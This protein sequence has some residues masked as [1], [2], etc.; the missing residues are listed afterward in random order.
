MLRGGAVT[1][2]RRPIYRDAA[3]AFIAEHHRHTKPPTG[4]LF[5]TSLWRG[6][7]LIGVAC[8]GRPARMMDDGLTI[9]ITRCCV[10]GER[11][12][13]ENALSTLYGALCRAAKALGYLVAYTYTLE[14]EDA[15]SVKASGFVLD[16]VLPARPS[17]RDGRYV[18]DLFGNPTRPEEA[19][20]R[21]KRVLA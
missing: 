10:K 7:E 12:A 14:S 11:R 18:E 8:A 20:N 6:D 21:W 16:A 5:G 17:A 19:K 4:W 13:F 2:T 15:A 9:E 1:L 3:R